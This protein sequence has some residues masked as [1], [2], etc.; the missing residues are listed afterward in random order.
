MNDPTLTLALEGEISL[1]AF[2]KEMHN[3]RRL[4]DE[5][6]VEAS[7]SSTVSWYIED[8]SSGSA[9]ATVRGESDDEEIVDSVIRGY[10][11]VARSLESGIWAGWSARVRQYANSLV[12]VVKISEKVTAVRFQTS[13][14]DVT[15]VARSPGES[16]KAAYLRAYG[17]IEGRVQTLSSRKGLRFTLYDFLY[18]KAVTCYLRE[19]Q[20][21]LIEDK[22][23]HRAIV[24]GL[25]SRDPITGR[26]VAIR[27]IRAVTQIPDVAEGS[28]KEARGI[29]SMRTDE[30]RPEDIIRRLRDAW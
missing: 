30:E 23:N 17:A 10:I 26:P 6:S 14:D 8:L 12:D 16:Q 3:W 9:L 2:V 20:E 22:W 11:D 13:E 18:D 7:G 27:E 28:Y 1:E 29:V 4:I 15:I 5:L 21:S 25:V 19:G 24:D